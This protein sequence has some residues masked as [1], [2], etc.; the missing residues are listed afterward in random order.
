MKKRSN[1]REMKIERNAGATGVPPS[2]AAIEF[3][4]E[5]ANYR[6]G[7]APRLRIEQL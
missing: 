3:D 4:R 7:P 5:M 2:Q 1:R 6:E